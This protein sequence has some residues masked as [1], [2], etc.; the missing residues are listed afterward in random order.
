MSTDSKADFP[1]TTHL[2]REEGKSYSEWSGGQCG[3]SLRDYF[4][5]QVLAGMHANPDTD[6]TL[7]AET[8][9]NIAYAT[10]DAM[11]AARDASHE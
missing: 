9:A 3:M 2:V 5:G 4:A 11:I 1:R 6:P 10:A 8:L 7:P